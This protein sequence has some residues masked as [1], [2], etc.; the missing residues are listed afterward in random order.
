M[1]N[2]SFRV[3]QPA[4][5]LMLLMIVSLFSCK[6]ATNPIKY[7]FGTFPDSVYNLEGINTAYDDYN[8]TI[9]VLESSVPIIFSSNRAST[10]GQFDLVSGLIS[11]TFDQTNG[12][13]TL[14]SEMSTDA[15]YAAIIAKANTSGNDFGPYTIFNNKDGYEY[16]FLASQSG[17]N[18]DLFYERYLP[19]NGNTLPVITGPLPLTRINSANDDAYLTFNYPM[20]SLYFCS[21]R[22]GNFD[23][24]VQPDTVL[25]PLST[26]LGQ[27][28]SASYL[29]DSLNSSADDK[30]PFIYKNVMVFA[31]NRDGGLGGFDLY[32]SIFRNGKWSA[33]VNFGPGI[34]TQ[35]DEYRPVVGYDAGFTN[36]MLI[37]SSNRPGGKGGYD[38]YFTGFT[39]PK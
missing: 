4:L 2:F 10:G 15:F 32:Y 25:T 16:L 8:S 1:K 19:R 36:R 17:D 37:F 39:F 33:P 24:Y 22:S 23:I 28:Y 14:S 12:K 6:K 13:F 35:Y 20:D 34:N 18:L 38:L 30:C 29:V 7:E 31:S 21:N 5:G 3:L 9:H 26:W 27:P 11:Y